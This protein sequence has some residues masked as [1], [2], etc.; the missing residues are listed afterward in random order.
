MIDGLPPTPIANPGP[1]RAGGGRQSVEDRRPLFRRRRHRRPCLCDRRSTSTTRMSPAGGRSQKKQAAEA[2]KAA[3]DGSRR[4]RDAAPCPR[5][6][7]EQS[8][9]RGPVADGDRGQGDTTIMTL[10]SMTG[11]AR[12][13]RRARRRCRS[14]GSS[15]RSTARALELRLRLPPGFERLEPAVRQAVAEALLARQHPGDAD[16]QRAAGACTPS[17]SSTKPS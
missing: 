17:R 9:R 8:V 4:V 13:R 2:A 14:P 1:R 15:S 6:A 7:R 5:P 11:F 10:Q 16:G 3:A 12:S